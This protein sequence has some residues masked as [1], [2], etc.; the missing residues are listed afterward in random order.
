MVIWQ[1]FI[2]II[3]LAMKFGL[4][5]IKLLLLGTLIILHFKVIP[6]WFSVTPPKSPNPPPLKINLVTLKQP[7]TPPLVAQEV[8]KNVKTEIAEVQQKQQIHP[9]T[10]TISTKKVSKAI[11][12]PKVKKLPPAPQIA[13]I[14]NLPASKIQKVQ[15][16]PPVISPQKTKII[17]P[18]PPV[19]AKVV[20]V[21]REEQHTP[22]APSIP[23]KNIVP[24]EPLALKSESSKIITTSVDKISE[25]HPENRPTAA[26][27]IISTKNNTSQG[28]FAAKSDVATTQK[29]IESQ[30]PQVYTPPNYRAA[31]LH[32]PKPAYPPLSQQ[33]EEEG[34]VNLLVHLDAR[35]QVRQVQLKSSC[36]YARLDTAALQTV[37]QWKF[38]PAKQGDSPVAATTIVPITFRLSDG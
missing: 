37:Q 3:K 25:N 29:A 33:L 11:P 18:P 20:P 5:P 17:P 14:T 16:K 36:G 38:I 19:V 34:T 35:G 1:T 27:S 4:Y 24:Q 30:Q 2:E 23:S 9:L 31:Y 26:G 8:P 13:K 12:I 28:N 21:K 6:Q 10:S 15:E 22:V 32:N 7:T